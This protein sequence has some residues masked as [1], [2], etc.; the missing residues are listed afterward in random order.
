MGHVS[1]VHGSVEGKR[2]LFLGFEPW[3]MYP[4]ANRSTESATKSLS[5]GVIVSAHSFLWL[6]I[7]M[8]GGSNC[9]NSLLL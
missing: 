2:L 1:A 3:T 9:Q 6:R 4:I 7:G 8:L 5:F